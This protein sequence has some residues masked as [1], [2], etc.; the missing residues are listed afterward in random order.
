MVRLCR[1]KNYAFCAE[2]DLIEIRPSL[3][4]LPLKTE[5][6]DSLTDGQQ[7]Y[8]ENSPRQQVLELEGA[9][10]QVGKVRRYCF[11]RRRTHMTTSSLGAAR[12]E[13][14][15]ILEVVSL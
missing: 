9:P 15:D 2:N 13:Y 10:P 8:K 11:R 12:K 6:S 4:A 14:P 5:R 3:Q 7:L 1:I